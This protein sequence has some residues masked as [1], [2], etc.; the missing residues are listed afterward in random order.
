MTIDAIIFDFNG[1]LVDDETIHFRGFQKALATKHLEINWDE[2]SE[3]YLPYDDRSFFLNFL[4]NRGVTFDTES[5][6]HLIMLKS[7]Y[8]FRM[9]EQQLPIIESS[10]NFI[11]QLNSELPLGIASGA[12]RKEINFILNSLKLL[13]R[14]SVIIAAEDVGN[15]KPHPEAF[16]K[17]FR[18]LKK[19][20]PNLSAERT[21]VIED[22]E[23]GIRSVH[24]AKMKCVGLATTY[25]IERMRA[26]DLVIKSLEGWTLER[27][28]SKL[29]QA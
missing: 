21:V 17:T 5:L 24:A 20:H 25:S 3:K 6:R 19:T 9:V 1:V 18:Y 7:A 4:S 13:D 11:L 10:I 12:A 22:S 23:R 27:L 16:L 29:S 14:F 28:E 8:Y 15:S 2:Y 26:A